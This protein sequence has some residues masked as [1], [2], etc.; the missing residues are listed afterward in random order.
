MISQHM[1]DSGGLYSLSVHLLRSGLTL[2]LE[3][4]GSLPKLQPIHNLLQLWS[5]SH[6]GCKMLENNK[7]MWFKKSAWLYLPLPHQHIMMQLSFAQ[8]T[9]LLQCF[10]VSHITACTLVQRYGCTLEEQRLIQKEGTGLIFERQSIWW[11]ERL[12]STLLSCCF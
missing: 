1:Q 8:N 7:K 4:S 5:Y 10:L 11:R 12:H 6:W 2:N 9:I 3:G